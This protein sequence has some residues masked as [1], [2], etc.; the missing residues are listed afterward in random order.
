MTF[1]TQLLGFRTTAQDQIYYIYNQLT[2]DPFSPGSATTQITI[3]EGV[4][5][6]SGVIIGGGGGGNGGGANNGSGGG[7]GAGLA[8]GTF[9]VEPG[10][11]LKINVGIGGAG[12]SAG[13]NGAEGGNSS[14]TLVQRG[15]SAKDVIILFA[16]GGNGG[17]I[18]PNPPE[19]VPNGGDGGSAEALSSTDIQIYATSPFG[20]IGFGGKGGRCTPGISQGAGGGGCGGYTGIGGSGGGRYQILGGGIAD[21]NPQAAAPNS[22]GGGGGGYRNLDTGEI[23]ATQGLGFGGGGVGAYGFTNGDPADTGVAGI[24]NISGGGGGSYFDDPGISI[25][26]LLV[27][28]GSTNTSTFLWS[29]LVLNAGVSGIQEGDF[30]LLISGSDSTSGPSKLDVPVG[31]TTI[32]FS[33][34]G[35][36]FI[37]STGTATE[38]IPS[39]VTTNPTRDLNFSTSYLF[40]PPS[41]G[42]GIPGLIV[43]AI[44]NIIVLRFIPRSAKFIWSNDSYDPGVRA[45]PPS[46]AEIAAGAGF[47]PNP[48]QLNNI[49]A[50]SLG[51]AFGFIANVVLNPSGDISAENSNLFTQSSGGRFGALGQGV[52]VMAQYSNTAGGTFG[53]LP[54]VSTSLSSGTPVNP[55]AFLTGTSSHARAYTMEIVRSVPAN[56]ITLVGA[57]STGDYFDFSLPTPFVETSNGTYTLPSTLAAGDLIIFANAF[58]GPVDGYNGAVLRWDGAGAANFDTYAPG[59]EVNESGTVEQR[60]NGRSTDSRVTN[61]RYTPN[62][63]LGFLVQRIV[64]PTGAIGNNP[65]IDLNNG[66]AEN[67]PSASLIIILRGASSDLTNYA[68]WDNRTANPLNPLDTNIATVYGPPDPP[69]ITTASNNSLVLSIG[70]VDNIAV[71]NVTNILPPDG[72]TLLDNK[73]YGVQNDGVIVMS[74]YKANL[75][76]GSTNPTAFSG[77]GGNIWAAQTLAIG[78]SGAETDGNNQSAGQWGGG[79]G[80]RSED[81]SNTGMS[82]ASGIARLI[83]G[84][85]RLYPYTQ[86][87]TGISSV[88]DFVV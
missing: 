2:P 71:S 23:P 67:L 65:F 20:Q 42:S 79:G 8:W 80:G 19:L 51:I 59:D 40:A 30:I 68:I 60:F 22:G 13:N 28:S 39:N 61:Q 86:G 78:G 58:D 50:G 47:M 87:N 15:G 3:P 34:N 35:E 37:N 69:Q 84:G 53:G 70:M 75:S 44:H 5:Q 56:P 74:A 12:G 73:S 16:E 24:N 72:W 26:P 36:Y 41:I 17:T 14:I 31:F 21:V 64:V 32:S 45:T 77:G 33:D 54:V 82:G 6:V 29:D 76:V 4:F 38:T 1:P 63:G 46:P 88:I 48:P 18:I 66:T 9:S 57:A 52:A 55:G 11:V 81:Y 25:A 49:I 62:N 27:G 10:D 83:W 85:S 7:G 43:P